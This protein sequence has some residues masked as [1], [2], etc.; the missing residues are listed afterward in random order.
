MTSPQQL[1]CRFAA[2]F[3]SRP[4]FVSKLWK[5]CNVAA[6]LLSLRA[7]LTLCLRDDGLSCGKYPG[8]K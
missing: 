1:V 6:A 5:T 4:H 2:V 8:G 7:S 3:L